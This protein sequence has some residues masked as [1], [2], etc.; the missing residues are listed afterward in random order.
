MEEVIRNLAHESHCDDYVAQS[1]KKIVKTS[2]W[3]QSIK[4]VFTAGVTKSFKYSMKKVK[5]MLKR[6]KQK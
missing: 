3:S 1:L 2:S 5:K 4:S 6:T